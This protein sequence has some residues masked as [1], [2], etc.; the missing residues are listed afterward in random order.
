MGMVKGARTENRAVRR[1]HTPGIRVVLPARIRV[2]QRNAYGPGARSLCDETR[3][4][5][6]NI[7]CQNPEPIKRQEKATGQSSRCCRNYPCHI[8]LARNCHGPLAFA[9]IS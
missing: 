4:L 7:T 6:G 5:D 2:A 8:R 3:V 9:D 1:C